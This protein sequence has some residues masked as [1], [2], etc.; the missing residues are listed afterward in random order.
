MAIAAEREREGA[1]GSVESRS[2][3]EAIGCEDDY[4][5]DTP[6]VKHSRLQLNAFVKALATSPNPDYES[7]LKLSPREQAYIMGTEDYRC[8]VLAKFNSCLMDRE[9]RM[10][11]AQKTAFELFFKNPNL[12]PAKKSKKAES[13]EVGPQ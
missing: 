7:L 2:L 1:G 9:D 3:S 13:F 4:N 11:R 10:T 8:L 12:A 5:S 6:L